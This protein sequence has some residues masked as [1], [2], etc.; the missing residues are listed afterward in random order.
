MTYNPRTK[1]AA[2]LMGEMQTAGLAPDLA[3]TLVKAAD[4]GR[5]RAADCR[6]ALSLVADWSAATLSDLQSD[7]S[8]PG[9]PGHAAAVQA[10]DESALLTTMAAMHGKALGVDK[11][12]NPALVENTASLATG[13]ALL[14]N[15]RR[16]HAR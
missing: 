15:M 2:R 8:V 10:A 7:A 1:L 4:E 14:D 16:R 11:Q 9:S 12:G 5:L 3:D 6:L 13:N